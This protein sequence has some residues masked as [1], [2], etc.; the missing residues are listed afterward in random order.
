MDLTFPE[1]ETL[2]DGRL[3]S[4]YGNQNDTGS[5]QVGWP[6]SHDREGM[7]LS[8]LSPDADYDGLCYCAAAGIFY[9]TLVFP[10][11]AGFIRSAT[12][13]YETGRN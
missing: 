10:V 13:R 6:L 12:H 5:F 2:D 7:V 1:L 11:G 3:I 4:V 9:E 8:L